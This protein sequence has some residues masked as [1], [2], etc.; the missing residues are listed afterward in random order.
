MKQQQHYGDDVTMGLVLIC[1]Y[2][3]WQCCIFS[4]KNTTKVYKNSFFKFPIDEYLKSNGLFDLAYI[5][6]DHHGFMEFTTGPGPVVNS[7]HIADV[8]LTFNDSLSSSLDI[9]I[10]ISSWNYKNEYLFI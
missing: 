10:F 9:I 3:M 2:K 4:C 5:T 6:G 1:R 8:G 7:M